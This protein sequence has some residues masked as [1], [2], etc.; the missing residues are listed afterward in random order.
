[1]QSSEG[2]LTVLV[3]EWVTG[4]GLAGS[5]MPQSWAD[6]GRAMRRAI[7]ADFAS[8]ARNRVHV[9][10]TLDAR[11]PDDPGPWTIE[12]IEPGQEVDRLRELAGAADAT[13]LVAPETAGTLARL[14]RDL[15]NAGT[16]VLGSSPAAI[17]LTGDKDR[18]AAW[19]RTR[20]VDTPMSRTILPEA[21]LPPDAR[22]PAVLKPVDGAGC[23]DTFY[24]VDAR[25][26]PACAREMSL[27]L[28]QPFVAGVPMS[29][30]FL[31]DGHGTA[32]LLGVGIQRIAIRDGRFAYQGGTLPAPS[33]AAEPQLRAAL[34]AIPGLRGFVGVDFVWDPE[35]QHATVLEINPRATTSCVGLTR[36]LPPGRLAEAWLRVFELGPADAA[37]LGG[38]A[39]LIH[40]GRRVC[41]NARGDRMTNDQGVLG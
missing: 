1:M 22:Y 7:A 18:L 16:R 41:F 23:V 36:L 21:G 40:G 28:L 29:A 39:E 32:W 38:L 5:P 11:L 17:D 25:S 3:H 30:S 14:T 27:A 10:V 31:V 37:W 24:V 35:T 33:R 6:E 12:R 26:L 4:G 20:G 15:R 13:V 8:V 9:I 19:L 2:S 34:G